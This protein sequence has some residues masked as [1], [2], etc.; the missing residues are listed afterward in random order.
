MEWTDDL[1]NAYIGYLTGVINDSHFEKALSFAE[2]HG[3]STDGIATAKTY[4][5]VKFG[6]V[7]VLVGGLTDG[8]VGASNSFFSA[9]VGGV[10]G[11]EAG[12]VYGYLLTRI[13]KYTHEI[14]LGHKLYELLNNDEIN[15]L[16][17]NLN[18]IPA[19]SADGVGPYNFSIGDI[20]NNGISDAQEANAGTGNQGS[21]QLII[22]QYGYGGTEY[23]GLTF[24]DSKGNNLGEYFPGG[25]VS[26]GPMTGDKG[27]IL[28]QTIYKVYSPASWE[29][30]VNTAISTSG[31]IDY[32]G[33]NVNVVGVNNSSGIYSNTFVGGVLS[34]ANIA[35]TGDYLSPLSMMSAY[36]GAKDMLSLMN[37]S[38]GYGAL[39]NPLEMSVSQIGAGFYNYLTSKYGVDFGNPT[40][41]ALSIYFDF[42]KKLFPNLEYDQDIKNFSDAFA[43]SGSP[44][45]IDLNRDGIQTTS[46][47]T[48]AVNFD[49]TGDGQSERTAWLSA[50]D[51]FL[52]YDANQNGKIDNISELFGGLNRGE[53]YAKLSEWDANGDSVIDASDSVFDQL[54]IWQ[55]VNQN[56]LTDAG[57]LKSLAEVDIS[58]LSLTYTVQ[59]TSNNG[60]LI[61]EVST[62]TLAGNTVNMADVY[63]QFYATRP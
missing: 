17:S 27:E 52:A 29:Q 15:Q 42:H 25:T 49:I 12:L 11:P 45:A 7:G 18:Q 36:N 60:N 51:G 63:F 22:T 19:S 23:L 24:I 48:G 14:K 43:E 57:E 28:D 2:Q 61:G 37:N 41:R 33:R 46:I 39:M 4:S 3:L 38:D 10:F 1:R 50:Q 44:I 6:L 58:S 53:G 62:A 34:A 47:M 21:P 54:S 26:Y 56:G 31:Y 32:L 35:N 20:N 30:A 59:D 16:I 8:P 13:S 55:D 5:A 40:S 9:V